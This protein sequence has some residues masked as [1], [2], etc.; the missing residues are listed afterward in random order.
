MRHELS[1]VTSPVTV[2]PPAGSTARQTFSLSNITD[3]TVW[4]KEVAAGPVPGLMQT[5]PSQG[6]WV[7]TATDT[8]C[9]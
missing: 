6:G 8:L 7:Q 3:E 1:P 9:P 2:T 4:V 5:A